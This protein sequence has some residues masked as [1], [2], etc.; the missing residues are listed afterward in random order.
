VTAADS[1]TGDV[2]MGTV[3]ATP[4][5]GT[6]SPLDKID[7]GAGVDTLKG[8]LQA[9]FTGFS[10]AGGMKNVEKVD[11]VA[12]GSA[13]RLFNATNIEGVNEYKLSG[14]VNLGNLSSA[15]AAVN[16]IGARSAD[17]TIGFTGNALVANNDS[18]K[19]GVTGVSGASATVPRV[20]ELTGLSA[21]NALEEIVITATGT[22]DVSIKSTTSGVKDITVAGKGSLGLTLNELGSTTVRK[23]DAGLLE[24]A[25]NL[26]VSGAGG[27]GV[28]KTDALIVGGK[29]ANDILTISAATAVGAVEMSGVESL[30]FGGAGT[31]SFD[32]A[33]TKGLNTVALTATAAGDKTVTNL[34]SA[35]MGVELRGTTA[36]SVTLDMDHGGAT[37]ISVLGGPLGTAA[38]ATDVGVEMTFGK[39]GAISLD[40]SENAKF[41]GSI[42]ADEAKSI[43]IKALSTGS[44]N[45]SVVGLDAAKLESI[46]VD[47]KG[48]LEVTDVV[49]GSGDFTNVVSLVVKAGGTFTLDEALEA[50]NSVDVSGAGRVK[51][52][53]IGADSSGDAANLGDL[54]VKIDG[55]KANTANAAFESGVIASEDNLSL[56]ATNL[57]GGSKEGLK[58]GD[59]TAETK[60]VTVTA[61]NIASTSANAV[62]IGNIAAETAATIDVSNVS[63]TTAKAVEIGS[64]TASGGEATITVTGASA[65]TGTAVDLGAVSGGTGATLS[66]SDASA[67]TGAAVKLGT[68]D[69]TAG[70]ASVTIANASTASTADAVDVGAITGADGATV[71]VGA[72]SGK[73]T[74]AGTT[75]TKG[76]GSL[77]VSSSNGSVDTGALTASGDATSNA[78]LKLTTTSV[79]A[80]HDVEIG[81]VTAGAA[82]KATVDL[83]GTK[84]VANTTATNGLITIGGAI[85]G[86]D[87]ELD[88][89]DVTATDLVGA[90]GSSGEIEIS[91]S[92]SVMIKAATLTLSDGSV[93]D[94]DVTPGGGTKTLD[95]T[96]SSTADN[97]LTATVATKADV[98]AGTGA[99][100]IS[101]T[102]G[103]SGTATYTIDVGADLEADEVTLE[104]GGG[105]VRATIEN[106][107]AVNDKLVITGLSVTG[108]GD[109]DAVDAADLPAADAIIKQF[110]VSAGVDLVGNISNIFAIDTDKAY[111]FQ[112]N[113]ATHIIYNGGTSDSAFD[114][115]DVFVTLVG[116]SGLE[117]ETAV[118]AIFA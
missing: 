42:T 34:G 79:N 90:S 96:G 105:K 91:A 63:A 116:V 3:S 106:F 38:V 19:L 112:A 14:N 81:A 101:L 69:T 107:R 26:K 111:V 9:D 36:N 10:S 46:E 54:T 56:T 1:A 33:N 99:D 70:V 55:L 80:A 49:S 29:G 83:S 23:V 95:Y 48:N 76:H 30:V 97:K 8:L 37:G 35:T 66:I 78:T 51:L 18:L 67:T 5:V 85:T 75:A 94:V 45:K 73:I 84:L 115:D 11:L 24:G 21:G 118:A 102:S 103:T 39:T 68:V 12:A 88:L 110:L 40:I 86:R 17:A 109:V 59:I 43:E 93:F 32:A 71:S 74:L 6:L 104:A 7:G 60:A 82:G 20:I 22:N 47:A 61:N 89:T 113:G 62:K 92:N 15:Q 53:D 114:D 41:T 72:T 58:V 25:F 117:T 87:V 98:V 100:V 2:I 77:T 4:G 108:V 57:T 31:A 27:A 52:G 50:A 64:I 65:T 44:V 28:F 13:S 16:F